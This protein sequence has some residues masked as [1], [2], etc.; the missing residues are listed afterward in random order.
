VSDDV[1]LGAFDGLCFAPPRW[2]SGS[3]GKNSVN[4][5]SGMPIQKILVNEGAA[6]SFSHQKVDSFIDPTQ[7]ADVSQKHLLVPRF[8]SIINL[9]NA[10]KFAF[11]QKTRTQ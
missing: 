5:F 11:F 7:A 4:L 10:N 8:L 1:I 6:P 2:D 3:K 9:R